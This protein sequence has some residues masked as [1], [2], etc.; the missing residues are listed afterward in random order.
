M[1]E[2]CPRPRPPA[3]TVPP[4]PDRDR[5]RAA[6]LAADRVRAS[7]ALDAFIADLYGEVVQGH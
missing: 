1:C 4:D 7:K 6:R 2:E 3:A 5:R